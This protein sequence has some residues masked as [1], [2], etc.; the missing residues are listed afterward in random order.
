MLMPFTFVLD[1]TAFSFFSMLNPCV[2]LGNVSAIPGSFHA[3]QGST[4]AILGSQSVGQ[5]RLSRH[6]F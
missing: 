5:G 3:I 2:Q 4:S 1:S 6:L